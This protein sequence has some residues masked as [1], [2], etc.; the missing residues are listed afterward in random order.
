MDGHSHLGTDIEAAMNQLLE[1]GRFSTREEV[2]REGVRLLRDR[3]RRMASID[4]AI[5]RGIEDAEDGRSEDAEIVLER[6]R[7]KYEAGPAK[8]LA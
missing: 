3:E 1:S 2:L 4:L 7:R 8:P 6:L 5:A